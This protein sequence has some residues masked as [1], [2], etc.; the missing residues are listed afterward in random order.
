MDIQIADQTG[1]PIKLPAGEK[2][3][4]T[5]AMALHEKGRQ[6]LKKKNITLALPLLL[7]AD[8]EFRQCS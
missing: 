1:K 5:L 4:L 2:T 8:K 3:A 6:A 7:E